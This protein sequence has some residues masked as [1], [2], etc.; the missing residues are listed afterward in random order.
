LLSA[1]FSEE[2]CLALGSQ[3]P[4]APAAVPATR[5]NPGQQAWSPPALFFA[6]FVA[7]FFTAFFAVAIST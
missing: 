6:D 5:L 3:L 7:D 4:L 1:F 2:V